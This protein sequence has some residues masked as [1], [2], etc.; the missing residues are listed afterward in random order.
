MSGNVVSL[1]ERRAADTPHLAGQ[2]RCL[3][4]RHDWIAVAP[5]GVV[6]LECPSCGGHRGFF[7]GP[8]E[9]AEGEERWECGTCGCQVFYI[10]PTVT[11]CCG[12]GLAQS[13]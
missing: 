2:A 6:W 10:G 8:C 4:C 1:A 9:P 11:R 7:G 12:C 13:F 3:A 5:V